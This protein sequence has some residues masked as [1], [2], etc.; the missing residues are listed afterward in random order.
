MSNFNMD[1]YVPVSDRIDAFY[2]SHP[3]GSIQSEIVELTSERVTIKATAYRTPDDPRPGVGHSSLEIPGKTSFTKGSEIEN[4]ETSA[5]GRAIAALGFEVKRG[6]ASAEEVRNKQPGSDERASVGGGARSKPAMTPNSAQRTPEEQA[7]IGQLLELPGMSIARMRLLA[8]AVGIPKGSQATADQLRE[9][10]SRAEQPGSGVPTHPADGEADLA[11]DSASPPT[12]TSERTPSL[13]DGPVA[14]TDAAPDPPPGAALGTHSFEADDRSKPKPDEQQAEQGLVKPETSSPAAS[15]A[16]PD[17]VI[18]EVARVTG[19]TVA[20]A[21]PPQPGTNA[22]HAL[23]DGVARSQAKAF[24]DTRKEPEP[25]Q[26]SLAEQLG[27]V[28]S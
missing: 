19:G 27:G 23:P 16:D 1:D 24:W 21:L 8:D 11:R 13:A 20:A 17:A 15:F 7:L 18:A 14:A 12:P 4:A 2:R 5:W 25:K 3:E 26:E 6:L 22:Y 9:M 28:S 10:L